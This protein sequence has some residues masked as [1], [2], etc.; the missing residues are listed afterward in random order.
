MAEQAAL[1]KMLSVSGE[2]I[3]YIVFLNT[4]LNK[5]CRIKEDNGKADIGVYFD[6]LSTSL[7][8]RSFRKQEPQHLVFVTYILF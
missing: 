6:V 3:N 5:M 4:G 1:T 2:Y 7:L 8:L